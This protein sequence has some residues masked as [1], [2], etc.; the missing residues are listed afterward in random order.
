MTQQDSDGPSVG[1]LGFGSLIPD[2]G[3]EIKEGRIDNIDGVMTPFHVEFA[4]SSGGR[5]GG[6]PTLVPVT[7]GGTQVKGKVFVMDL[8][9]EKATDVLFRRETNQV[10]TDSGYPRNRVA[11]GNKVVVKRLTDFTGLD[12]V[13][14]THIAANIEPLTAEKLA[15]HAIESVAKADP[16]KDGISYLIDAKNDGIVTVLSPAYEAEILRMQGCDTLEEALVKLR[17]QGP[18]DERDSR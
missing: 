9:E 18:K 16:G 14:Y 15:H 17:D 1:I 7:C 5:R 3:C 8:T 12:V 4:R 6:A 13:L 2:P 10:C 11:N